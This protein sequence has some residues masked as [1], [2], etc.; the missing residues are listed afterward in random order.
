MKK[1]LTSLAAIACFGM[2]ATAAHATDG[3]VNFEGMVVDVTCSIS[4]GN[5]VGGVVRLPSIAA[6][7]LQN[8]DTTAGDTNFSLV[9]T[10]CTGGN[11]KKVVA[12]FENHMASINQDGRLINMMETATDGATGVELE[13]LDKVT[14]DRIILGDPSQLQATNVAIANEAATLEYVVRYFSPS[15]SATAGRVSSMLPYTIIYQ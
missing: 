6:H 5:G 7:A 1:I 3:V 13:V 12:E 11:G 9:L 10:G 8:P 4:V 2:A 14:G 15:G